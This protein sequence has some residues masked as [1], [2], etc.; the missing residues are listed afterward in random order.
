MKQ[1]VYR[2]RDNIFLSILF[3]ACLTSSTTAWAVPTVEQLISS[4]EQIEIT[5]NKS[6]LLTLKC[7]VTR[8]SVVAPE[9]ADVQ[10]LEPKQILIT[11]KAV[12][13]TSLLFWTEDEKT[14]MVD[15]SVIWNTKQIKEALQTTM[16]DQAIEAV[17]LEEGVALQGEVQSL[18]GAARAVE[19]A[20]S[21]APKVINMLNVP[22]RHQVLLKVRVAEVARSFREELGFNFL[23]SKDS[24]SGGSTLGGLISGDLTSTGSVEMSDAVTLFLGLPNE[25]I[26]SFVQAL[27][28]KGLISIL[29][30]PNLIARSGETASFL[31]GG[32]FP[33]PVVQGGLSNSVSIEYKEFGVRLKFTPTV[34]EDEN[35][36]LDISP[37]VSDLDFTQGIKL[38]GF[39]V[40]VIVTRRAHTVIQLQSGQTFAIAGL[41]NKTKQK[42]VRKIPGLGEIPILGGLFRGKELDE[43][44]TEL[45]IM[46]TPYLVAPMEGAETGQGYPMPTDFNESVE[47]KME[48]PTVS[49]KPLSNRADHVPDYSST[50]EAMYKSRGISTN[51]KY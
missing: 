12:G 31:A 51:K 2:I 5:I 4:S 46:V 38:G 14:R 10:I 28:A 22:G 6:H 49:W 44:E 7:P 24:L 45:L 29:A 34:F 13:E 17:S 8:V 48:E 36:H 16:P 27:K 37:E 39:V 50:T 25:D 42:T 32:E 26:M 43:K 19:I 35:I 30:Q 20:Q 47:E 18:D 15:V 9:I 21:Y 1:V 23:V 41:I 33:I 11:G 40:P 3:T